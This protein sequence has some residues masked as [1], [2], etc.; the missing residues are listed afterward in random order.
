MSQVEIDLLDDSNSLCLQEGRTLS[1]LFLEDG[2]SQSWKDFLQRTQ[3][4]VVVLAAVL[5]GDRLIGSDVSDVLFTAIQE[6]QLSLKVADGGGQRG[7]IGRRVEHELVG[8]GAL[9]GQVLEVGAEGLHVLCQCGHF[10][11]NV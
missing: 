2:R 9:C 3:D 10:L 6:R 8:G 5:E 4:L 11:L 1:I 7:Q